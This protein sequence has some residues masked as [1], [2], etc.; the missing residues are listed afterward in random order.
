MELF[1]VNRYEGTES[2]EPK[3]DTNHLSDLLKK[4]EERKK[5]KYAQSQEKTASEKN[6]CLSSAM[7]VSRKK[8]KKRKI[9][10][11]NIPKETTEKSEVEAFSKNLEHQSVA[12]EQSENE[13]L[14]N[15]KQGQEFMI[16][17]SG[18]K[19]KAKAVHRVLPRWLAHPEII[20]S[21]LSS[22]PDLED[23]KGD[24]DPKLVEILKSN[25]LVKL[26]PVQA[27][28]I[29]WLLKCNR[30]RRIGW[31]PRDT[32]VSAP[33]GSGKTLAYVLPVIQHLQSR[34]VPK[35]RC[36]AVLPVQEL[37]AQV[38]KVFITYSAH[39]NLRVSLVSGAA[40][41][42]AEQD[43]LTKKSEGG[44]ISSRVDIVVATPGRLIDHIEKTAGFSL[45]DL[46]YLIIDEADRSTDWLQYIP[47][48]HS[49]APPLT[50]GN[51][52]TSPRIP[53]QKLLF[54]ATLSQDPEKLSRLGLLQPILFTSVQI[55]DRDDDVDLD[56]E[57]DNFTG[58]YTSPDELK[59]RAIKCE[60]EY[61][62]LA[63]RQL[64]VANEPIEKTL[65]FTNSGESAHRLAIL[66][67]S[68]VNTKNITVDELSAQLVPK[69]RCNVLKKFAEGEID[70]LIS[71]DAL[72]RGLDIPGI[73]LVVAY[74]LPKH[75]EGYI[76]RA[77]RTARAGTPGTAVSILTSNQTASFTR[78]LSSANKTVPTLES[79]D[80][81]SEIAESI[82]YE[83]HIEKLKETLAEEQLASSEKGKMLK[84]RCGSKK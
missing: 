42:E 19:K 6:Q 47:A 70:V 77:G 73:K 74:D 28:I 69:Q 76:H 52:L 83:E 37:A 35:I 29:R 5:Q 41:F 75:I 27:S 33:T 46:Q 32:C 60:A 25:G 82:N 48:P 56:K 39:T 58:R 68:I 55:S 80:S 14:E 61:K 31:W 10:T 34:L 81:L 79:F 40:S 15:L 51:V 12:L 66:L 26:F 9:K 62:P 45:D 13:N 38:Y 20:S 22:G 24:L 7:G 17:G 1:V 43:N 63:L 2:A 53:A 36:L 18:S 21:D 11:D 16:L 64:L 71:S 4:I 44:E 49:R 65:V 54:S 78:M 23:L 72:A 3:S 50:L 67:R 8:A 30:D 84:R 59:E 57:I